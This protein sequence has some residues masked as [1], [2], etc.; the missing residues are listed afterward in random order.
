MSYKKIRSALNYTLVA[1]LQQMRHCD[2]PGNEGLR[3]T[4][5]NVVTNMVS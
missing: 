2:H 5:G 1:I 3:Y 4:V